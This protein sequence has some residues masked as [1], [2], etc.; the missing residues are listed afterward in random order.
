MT[1][2]SR[3]QVTAPPSGDDVNAGCVGHAAFG[4]Q[5]RCEVRTEVPP[6]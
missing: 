2:P 5:G 4:S 6:A 3:Q 1:G